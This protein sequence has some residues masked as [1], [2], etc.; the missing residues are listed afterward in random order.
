ME[1]LKI[2][3]VYDVI[4]PWVKG[5]V[6][7]RIYEL[8]R[9]LAR[10][11]EVHV[12]GY[13]H[14]E[15]KNE[16]EREGIHYHGLALAPERLY[17]L[18]K[19]NPFPMLRLAGILSRRINE[20]K[21]F[22]V[23]DVQNLFYPGA[24][25]LK[26]LPNAVVTWHEF[27]GGY[28]FSYLGLAG[29]FGWFSERALFT[30]ERHISVSWKTKRDLLWAGL[31][32]PVS[33]VPNGVDVKLID[34]I[35]PAEFESD[36]I[37]VGRLIPEKGVDILLRALADLKSEMPDVKAVIVGDGPERAK[38]EGIAKALNLED[39]VFFTG[40]LPYERVIALMKASKVFVLPSR[41]EGFG[42]VA[43]E[44]MACGLPAITLNAPMNA[45]RF[46]VEEGKNGFVVDESQLSDALAS[47]LFDKV[48]LK[49]IGRVSREIS[50]E[51]DWDAVV[52]LLLDVYV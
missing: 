27:W 3:F 33:L 10:D 11:H 8:A 34:S 44:A 24:L 19:R 29:A 37:F 52:R 7:R 51:Y 31:R 18:G 5:G 6:E 45:A 49:R 38:L 35:P 17:L 14:W 23:V 41:R 13:R 40:F 1:T 42:M 20:F 26:R 16:I 28:W 46:L 21:Q 43:L 48:F 9:R 22:D 32:R 47:L 12:Y 50:E 30:A 2:A 25:A 39:N 4:Y 36:V 15:G